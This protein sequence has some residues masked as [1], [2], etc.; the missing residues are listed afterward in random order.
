VSEESEVFGPEELRK[1]MKANGIEGEVIEVGS[2]ATSESAASSL[3]APLD[4]IVKSVLFMDKNRRPI[5]VIMGGEHKLQQNTFAR[6]IGCRKIRLATRDEV[7]RFT[8]YPAGGVPPM[9]VKQG[10]RIFVDSKVMRKKMV[11]AGGGSEKHIL[12]FDAKIL[13]KLYPNSFVD[14]P[15]MNRD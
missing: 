8:G 2:G 9:G 10:V 13:T 15:V 6:L 1:Y 4:S 7:L 14:L 5:L 11:Y 12:K 3:E